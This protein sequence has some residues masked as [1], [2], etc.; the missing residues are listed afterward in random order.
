MSDVSGL[1]SPVT[2]RGG[3]AARSSL[4]DD[5]LPTGFRRTGPASPPG[6]CASSS[7]AWAATLCS[8]S[9]SYRVATT[10]VI[11]EK[12]R[13]PRVAAYPAIAHTRPNN[14]PKSTVEITTATMFA[15][16]KSAKISPTNRP[17]HRP[18][19]RRR[20]RPGR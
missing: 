7:R 18:E 16:A 17:S 1:M 4:S 19:R 6:S 12:S 3:P 9:T 14:A 13:W 2:Y 15:S 11:E 5:R 8:T 20:R 10:C